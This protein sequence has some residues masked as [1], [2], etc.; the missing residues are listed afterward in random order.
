MDALAARLGT[1]AAPADADTDAGV[2]GSLP[3]PPEPHG[4]TLTTEG[5][6]V[7]SLLAAG[8]AYGA[9]RWRRMRFF[10]AGAGLLGIV[11]GTVAHFLGGEVALWSALGLVGAAIAAV[12]FTFI[13]RNMRTIYRKSPR[14]FLVRLVFWLMVSV[15]VAISFDGDWAPTGLA[16]F[17][18]F[19]FV[20]IPGTGRGGGSGYSSYS[21]SGSSYSSS[22]DSSSS[23]SSDSSSS[24]S[25]DSG[26]S[27]SG[28]GS[29]GDW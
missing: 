15:V 21:S 3:A 22:S 18:A 17:L 2:V 11:L 27:S 9:Y 28:G 13:G 29:S 20:F 19:L 10:V 25:S 7:L 14:G 23:S 16:S 12:V 1:A 24:R 5:V 6:V 8:L 4:W 26:G